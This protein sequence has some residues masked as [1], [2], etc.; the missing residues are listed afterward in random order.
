M[1]KS[2][3]SDNIIIKD[4]LT[5][6]DRRDMALK[7]LLLKS[8]Y[9]ILVHRVIS[10]GG[11]EK[12]Q[13]ETIFE[14]C[15]IRL[16]KKVR[17]FEWQNKDTLTGFFENEARK[18]WCEELKLNKTS[19]NDVLNYINSDNKLKQQISGK[20]MKNSGKAEDAEDCYQNG[21]ILLDAKLREGTYNGGAIKGF[22]YQLCFNLW[23][24]ELKRNKPHLLENEM[25]KTSV[26]ND[27]PSLIME[28]KEQAKLLNLLFDKMGETCKK[29]MKLKYFI[30]DQYSMEEIAHQMG[31]KNAQIASN[32]LSKCRKKLWEMLEEHK[33]ELSWKSSI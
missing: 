25:L 23:R 31:F 17:R 8:G 18:L 21:M 29:L 12:K 19:R 11:G 14:D 9:F 27:D 32:T 15:L 16:D 20:I 26:T 24:N 33:Q 22:F 10:D 30:I 1:K 4:I 7:Y 3:Y 2:K 5:G 6:G 28:K 13:A